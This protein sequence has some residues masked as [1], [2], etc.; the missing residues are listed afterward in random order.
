MHLR[1]DGPDLLVQYY[2]LPVPVSFRVGT[3]TIIDL[4]PIRNFPSELLS[5]STNTCKPMS[6]VVRD[7]QRRQVDSQVT[8]IR[9]GT[10]WYRI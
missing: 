2:I 8:A 6:S 9:D 1:I 3:G 7:R 5:Y 10:H 4:V